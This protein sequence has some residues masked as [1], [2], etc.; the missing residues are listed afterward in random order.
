MIRSSCPD[1]RLIVTRLLPLGIGLVGA[2]PG[3]AATNTGNRTDGYRSL[4]TVGCASR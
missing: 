2:T 4:E 1:R 3:L